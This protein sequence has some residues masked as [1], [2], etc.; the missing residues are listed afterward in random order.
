[1]KKTKIAAMSDIHIGR[2]D[3][4]YTEH[5]KKVSQLAEILIICGDLTDHGEAEEADELVKQLAVCTIPVVTVLGN[6][7]Y[8]T[9]EE[10]L[11]IHKLKERKIYVL[12]G[13]SAI[14]GD[15]GFA[16]IK[17]FCGGFD[18]YTLASWG[19]KEIKDFV[20]VGVEESLQLEKALSELNTQ[21]KIVVMHYSP[22]SDTVKGE[23]LELYPFLGCSRLV[24]PINRFKPDYVFHGHAHHGTFKGKTIDGIPVYNVSVPI[25]TKENNNIPYHIV[26]V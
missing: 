16:G 25:V 26:E 1:M 2:F 9:G 22:I 15:I 23:P 10:K 6:H 3:V 19:E 12:S 18:Q 5:F 13:T 14:I 8:E 11:L 4:D 17:G 21:K 24:T 20:R 7:D